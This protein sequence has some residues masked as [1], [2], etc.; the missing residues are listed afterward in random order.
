M[1]LTDLQKQILTPFIAEMVRALE[2]MAGLIA[3]SGEAFQDK[4]EEFRFKGYAVAA[5]THG[6]IEGVVLLHNYVETALAIGN[7]LRSKML[8]LTDNKNEIDDEMQGALAE[9]GNTVIGR[10]TRSLE[11]MKLGIVFE[12]PFFI[13]NTKDMDFMMSGVREIVS[14]PIH[15]EEVGRFYFNYLLIDVKSGQREDPKEKK[16][17]VVDDAKFIRLAIKKYLKQLGY[18]N[19]IEASNGREAVEMHA[20]E[21]PAIIFLDVVMPELAG[22]EALKEIRATDSKTPIV[23]LS[24]VA[25]QTVV[26]ECERMGISGYIIKPLTAEDGPDVLKKFL[27]SA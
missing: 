20:K 9:W 1:E 22:N 21:K 4:V 2:S 19:I 18:E 11:A 27:T 13:L 25:D 14:I 6:N 5:R 15:I 24:S 8:D 10:A 26:D 7:G 12:P 16:I 17:M 3:N 23:M